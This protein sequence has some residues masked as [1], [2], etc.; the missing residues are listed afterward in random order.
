MELSSLADVY[1]S[2]TEVF[3]FGVSCVFIQRS[4]LGSSPRVELSLRPGDPKPGFFLSCENRLIYWA[5]NYVV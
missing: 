2:D 4:L 3:F 1:I 5:S